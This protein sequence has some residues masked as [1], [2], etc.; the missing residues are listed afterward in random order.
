MRT[1]NKGYQFRRVFRTGN[2]FR[3]EAFRAIYRFN[4]LGEIRLGFSLSSKSGNAVQRNLMRRR[5]KN[6]SIQKAWEVGADIVILPEGK[7]KGKDWASVKKDFMKLI[8]EIMNSK[9]Q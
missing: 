7:L 2:K 4:S 8:S 9:K 6:L 3:G 1:L 5:I